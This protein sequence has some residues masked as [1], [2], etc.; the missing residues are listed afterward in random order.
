MNLFND[1]EM[2]ILLN[3]IKNY[4]DKDLNLQ[5][6]IKLKD[7]KGIIKYINDYNETIIKKDSNEIDA[8]INPSYIY[9][10]MFNFTHHSYAYLTFVFDI[11]SGNNFN[12]YLFVE[13]KNETEFSYQLHCELINECVRCIKNSKLMMIENIIIN[14]VDEID[15]IIKNKNKMI[16][17]LFPYLYKFEDIQKYFDIENV[18]IDNSIPFTKNNE[19]N[20]F[21]FKIWLS[22][23]SH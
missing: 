20:N 11:C 12:E 1:D 10:P 19:L 13:Y 4:S 3:F 17:I 18:Y 23:E 7:T 14:K 22:I 16:I 5:T 21:I 9:D 6:L 15:E 8:Y 2:M